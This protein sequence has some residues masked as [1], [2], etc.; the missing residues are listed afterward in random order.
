VPREHLEVLGQQARGVDACED[1]VEGPLARRNLQGE[2]VSPGHGVGPAQGGHPLAQV[3]QE[4]AILP[5]EARPEASGVPGVHVG[6][7]AL[8]LAQLGIIGLLDIADDPPVEP[9]DAGVTREPDALAGGDAPEK[10]LALDV[11]HE[12]GQERRLAARI[13][14]L[15]DDGHGAADQRPVV[16]VVRPLAA[17]LE[18]L[19]NRR[20]Q[21]Q[22]VIAQVVVQLD[23]PGEQRPAGLDYLHAPEARR[24][25]LRSFL[26]RDDAALVDVH[27]PVG[28]DRERVVHRDHA[29]GHGLP[30]PRERIDGPELLRQGPNWSTRGRDGAREGEPRA[31]GCH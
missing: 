11:P 27:D 10:A 21:R 26:D 30:R 5:L 28:L 29:P 22:S 13:P 20:P 24:G 14:I 25:G 8:R 19:R 15:P 23:Q 3:Q 12:G 1:G 31:R 9:L 6:D 4:T 18:T 2:E 16:L 7:A 17:V